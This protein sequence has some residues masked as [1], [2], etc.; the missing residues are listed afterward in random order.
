MFFTVSFTIESLMKQI[1]YGLVIDNGSYLRE[2][3][4]VIDYFIVVSSLIDL[5]LVEIEL[6]FIKILRLLRTLR[7]L[8]FI[9][10]NVAMK[11]IVVALFESVGHI[12]N[13]MVVVMIVWLMFAILGV[14]LFSGKFFYCSQD[15][16]N[17]ETKAECLRERGSW[18]V[19]DSNFDN[20]GRAMLTL[21]IIAS[22][23]DWPDVMY[24]A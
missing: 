23:E 8:R 20:V 19:Y 4:N 11:M 9:S 18:Q 1:A 10:H 17:T 15:P 12:F 21:F 16:Y 14:N 6:P 7:P 22:E 2:T 3:W 5:C 24:Q 13:V